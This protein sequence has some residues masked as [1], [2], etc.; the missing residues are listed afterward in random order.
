MRHTVEASWKG[1][2]KFDTE[3]NGHHFMMDSSLT[4]DGEDTGPRPKPLM[5]AALAGCTGMDV[6]SL[7]KKMRQDIEF[8]NVKVEGDT[9]DQ[10]P[11]P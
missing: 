11:N 1:N 5:L 7:L 10:H 6:V 9:D 3:V 8:F 4:N 2:M